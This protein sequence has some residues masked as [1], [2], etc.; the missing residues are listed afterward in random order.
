M[1]PA[2][3]RGVA[4][5]LWQSARR[6]AASS[7]RTSPLVVANCE[8]RSDFLWAARALGGAAAAFVAGGAVSR[9]QC[10]TTG[11]RLYPK[12]LE[13]L[14]ASGGH[15]A[16]ILVQNSWRCRLTPPICSESQFKALVCRGQEI[17][18]QFA[19][20]SILVE[21]IPYSIMKV[22]VDIH[23]A[24]DSKVKGASS[25]QKLSLV[26]KP[27]DT[28]QRLKQRVTLVEPVPFPEQDLQLDGASLKDEQR[29]GDLDLHEGQVLNLTVRAS[30]TA[31]TDQLAQLLKARP[32]SAVELGL[33]YT[34][35]FGATV[36]TA[37]NILGCP[38]PLSDFLLRK[39]RFAIDPSGFVS[40][41]ECQEPV[42]AKATEAALPENVE[43]KGI[44]TVTSTLGNVMEAQH[45]L[46][47][48]TT[49]TVQSLCDR[50]LA[51]ELVPFEATKMTFQGQ[52]LEGRQQLGF[53]KMAAGGELKVHVEVSKEL[54]CHQLAG[55]L[56]DRGLSF[57]EL[58][59]LYCYR[60]GAPIRRGLELLG[61]QCTLKEFLASAPEYFHVESG[62]IAMRGTIPAR[63][64]TGDL[65]QRYL[66]L[67][68]QI[69]RCKLVKDAAAALEQV[70]QSA[71]G[72]PLSVGRTIFLGSVGRGT[73][74]EGSVDAQ[75]LLLINGKPA[76]DR[77]KWLP[78]LLPSLAAALSQDLGEKARVSVTDEAVH[79]HI[80]G[81]S[82]EVVVDAVG[83][84]LALA[85][86]RSARL[87]DKLPTAV[88]VTMRLMKWWRNQQ[89]WSSD[90]E[91]PSDLLLEHIVAST[92]SP[93]PVDQVAAV[94]AAFMAL[95]S[96]DHLSVV[97][98][99]D[100]TAKLG[101]SKNFKHQQL[102]EL[103]T[104]SAG[105]LMQ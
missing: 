84:P 41:S 15:L 14:P 16:A 99:M 53:Y 42:Q 52:D 65:N 26:V 73:A 69:S 6:I 2:A 89:P 104:K 3:Q 70:C 80:A 23:F 96:F 88:K 24:T 25:N 33:L 59:D 51:S 76:T 5:F 103:A 1:A 35:K 39:K 91:R 81:V 12:D 95:A 43:I 40:L 87:F 13:Q 49:H 90:E 29:L 47:A 74:I 18:R 45:Q 101:D 50:A 32:L 93:A 21:S 92:T 86:D 20:L 75:A 9:S 44:V 37:L 105:R 19:C 62:C 68:A 17:I 66:Q 4:R 58:G 31:F 36:K 54:L 97:D 98:P 82:V 67:D 71:R 34:H 94:S 85:A 100:P 27:S 79:V 57:A 28:V 83:G 77:Q 63:S 78:P 11:H 30:E 56:Q 102:V 38:E 46:R 64:A 61:L 48:K 10:D 72:S 22:T 8:E 7:R 55:L 60:Y